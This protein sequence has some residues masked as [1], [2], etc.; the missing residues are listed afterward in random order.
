MSQMLVPSN[1][2]NLNGFPKGNVHSDPS[3]LESN[4]SAG[5]FPV[6]RSKPK[7]GAW[8]DTAR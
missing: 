1:E 4:L 2:M 3:Q 8:E 5:I 7:S 6:L